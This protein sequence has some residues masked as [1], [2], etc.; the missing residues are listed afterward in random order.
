MTRN[1]IGIYSLPNT[2][3]VPQTAV[4]VTPVNGDMNDIASTMTMTLP[5]NGVAPMTG[6]LKLF[7][8][9]VNN[10][11][12]N[13]T[14]ALQTGW[15]S[16]AA[17][18]TSMAINGSQVAKIN[19]SGLTMVSSNI[20]DK[21]SS[22]VY[23]LPIG[24][25]SPY[26]G[27]TVPNQWLLCYGQAISRTTYSAAFAVLSTT[28]GSGDGLL[29]FNLPDLRGRAAF[30]KDNMGGIAA[31]KITNAS[32]GITG[33]T[34]GASGGAQNIT[35]A[36][37]NMPNVGT[38]SS[39]DPTHAHNYVGPLLVCQTNSG[40]S[41]GATGSSGATTGAHAI[42]STWTTGGSGTALVVLSPGIIMNYM[43]YVGV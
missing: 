16:S 38:F 20:T 19:A 35:I 2:A 31:N 9:V 6:A 13:F 34:L 29:T 18:E 21:N 8:G 39:T 1:T 11:S 40:A 17:N 41:S 4:A 32:S 26:A 22:V 42:A 27:G 12:I 23:G 10:P 36:Q 43:I 7:T 33:T 5:I 15:Y 3:F 14:T 25:V 30:G 37:A 24:V 28:F